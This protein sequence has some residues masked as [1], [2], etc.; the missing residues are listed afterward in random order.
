VPLNGRAPKRNDFQY[1]IDQVSS[2]LAAW[3]ANHLSFAGRVTLAKSVIEAI[4]IYPMMSTNIPKGCLDE[5]HKM[6]RHF[7]WGDTEAKRR[8][9]AVGWDNI[10]VPKWM[11]GLGL[12]KLDVMNRACLMKLCWKFQ[13]DSNAYWCKV[14]H[15]KYDN[16]TN[17]GI[18]TIKSVSSSLWKHLH[19]NI[20]MINR[21]SNWSV[22][23]GKEIDAW[24]EAWID[25]GFCVNDHI[26]VPQHLLSLKVSDL[27]DSEGKWNWSLFQ[28]WMPKVLM[29]KI[30]AILPP[31]EEHGRDERYMVGNNNKDFSIATAYNKLCDFRDN[32][33]SSLWSKIWKLHVPERVRSFMWLAK[34]DRLLTNL[35]RRKMGHSHEMCNF[36]GDREEDTLHV[37]RDCPLALV[38]WNHVVPS[39]DKGN[40][41]M[42]D[43]ENW[44]GFNLNNYVTWSCNIEWGDYWA[45]ACHLLWSWRNK[46][47][48]EEG[49]LRPYN[50]AQFIMQRATEYDLATKNDKVVTGREKVVSHIRWRPPKISFVKLNTDGA[51]KKDQIAG[52]GGI[53]RGNQGEWLGGYAKCVGLCSAF[54]AELWGV[55]EGLR[56]VRRLGFMNV[57]LNIDSVAVVQVLK[58]RRFNS[59]LGSA[60]I[61]Q[62]WKLLDM[63]WNI[64]IFHTYREANKCADALANLGCSLGY[65]LVFFDDCPLTIRETFAKDNMGISTPR[66]ICL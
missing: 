8:Y 14:L 24:A 20:Q 6:Q 39:N 10:S 35:L 60:L 27:V 31:N 16:G 37:L 41:F 15:G 34:H 42:C 56:C 64:E 12:R 25:D 17:T 47:N 7:I 51:Y 66:L 52:C 4:P 21:F 36:C 58:E 62:I 11:G 5:I 65:D 40:F 53:I 45:T 33:S 19:D 38:I 29:D 13:K 30:A 2:K 44:M 22:G 3:K 46:E 48:H 54:V 55:L 49:F 61:K 59:S 57:E 32:D 1:L 63:D 18:V 23:N 43:L 9:H 26:N 50:P 28:N